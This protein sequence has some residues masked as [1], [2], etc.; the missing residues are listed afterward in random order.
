MVE[1][2]LIL[3]PRAN[4]RFPTTNGQK[5]LRLRLG[6][7]T[8][9]TSVSNVNLS[10]ARL[11]PFITLISAL[12][13]PLGAADICDPGHLQ[14]TYGFQLS[15]DTTISGNS[16]P[17]TSLSRLVFDGDGGLSGYSSV[18]FAGF[19][20]GN[21]VTGSYEVG[22]DCKMSWSLQ[23]DSGAFQ[24]FSGVITGKRVQFVQ[25]DPG[26]AQRGIAARTSDECT[27]LDLQKKYDFTLS[28]SSIPMMP[29]E[30]SSTVAAEGLIAADDSGNFKLTL[31]D[32]PWVTTDVTVTVESDCFVQIGLALPAEAGETITLM[33]LRG[34][35]LNDGREILAIQTDPGAS[36][37]ARFTAHQ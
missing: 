11:A 6:W 24:H 5:P 13:L 34:I 20:L 7:S 31:R 27:A 29:G 4:A 2:R 37:S 15:G 36:V 12:S 21:P 22:S 16:R 3:T 26:G 30:V 8:I 28:G 10:R 35:L 33:T 23:D 19:L 25:T 18:M 14:G 32:H 9:I 17:V 1:S